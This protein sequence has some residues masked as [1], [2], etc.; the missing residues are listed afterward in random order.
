[1]IY[2]REEEVTNRCPLSKGNTEAGRT[3]TL[4]RVSARAILNVMD[5]DVFNKLGTHPI[6]RHTTANI[7]PC[8]STTPSAPR[9]VDQVEVALHKAK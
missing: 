4:A 2:C 9:G 5:M 6:V 8:R 3:E 7:H 1:M